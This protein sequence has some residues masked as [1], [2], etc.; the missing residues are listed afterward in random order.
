MNKINVGIDISEKKFDV[1][2]LPSTSVADLRSLTYAQ[3][4]RGEGV[5]KG[6]S[7]RNLLYPFALSVGAKRRSRRV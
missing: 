1:C 4:E 2:W 7:R 5:I 6:F 3:D